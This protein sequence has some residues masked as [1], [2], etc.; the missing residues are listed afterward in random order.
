LAEELQGQ[1]E[2]L[3]VQMIEGSGGVFVVNADGRQVYSKKDTGR[4]PEPGE[5]GKAISG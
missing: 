4:F 3:D 5:V 1:F 2:N